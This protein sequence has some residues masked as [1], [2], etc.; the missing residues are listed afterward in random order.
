MSNPYKP[1]DDSKAS[2][3]LGQLPG[4]PTTAPQTK[5]KESEK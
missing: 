2:I 5:G 4:A 3:S 1:I